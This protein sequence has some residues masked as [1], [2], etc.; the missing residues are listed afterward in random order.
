MRDFL[1]NDW[2][3]NDE[4]ESMKRWLVRVKSRH[5]LAQRDVFIIAKDEL[6][7]RDRVQRMYLLSDITTIC[8]SVARPRGMLAAGSKR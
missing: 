1:L 6:S 2:A 3:V 5:G 8:Q 4:I 7:A